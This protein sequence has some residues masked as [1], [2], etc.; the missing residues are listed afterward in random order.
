MQSSIYSEA[1]YAF[2]SFT[3]A[4]LY[5]RNN[6]GRIK[7]LI[8]PVSGECLKYS[9]YNAGLLYSKCIPQTSKFKHVLRCWHLRSAIQAPAS[10]ER[11]YRAVGEYSWSSA[12]RAVWTHEAFGRFLLY[13]VRDYGT[14]CLHVD[15]CVTLTTSTTIFGHS[16]KTFF[17]SEYQCIQRIMGFGDYALYKSMFY[18]LTFT[19]IRPSGFLCCG[20][21]GLELTTDWLPW[22]VCRFWCFS[23]HSLDDTIRAILVQPWNLEN[24]MLGLVLSFN[25]L[26]CIVETDRK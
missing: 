14:L 2:Q 20:S 23:A 9:P 16:L 8:S 18:L 10:A 7:M 24:P 12:R 22:S 11:L 4:R 25:T 19:Y 13:S 5:V 6:Q 21:D 17:L 3:E 15:C 1:F 26:L